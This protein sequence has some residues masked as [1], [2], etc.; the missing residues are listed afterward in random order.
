MSELRQ[1]A[2]WLDYK[3]SLMDRFNDFSS[4]CKRNVERINAPE[5]FIKHIKGLLIFL[6]SFRD[7]YKTSQK[8][9]LSHNILDLDQVIK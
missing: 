1:L 8:Y 6:S 3:L 7:S 5:I 2:L 4:S 9:F